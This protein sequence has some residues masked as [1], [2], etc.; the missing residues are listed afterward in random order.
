MPH[1]EPRE[2]TDQVIVVLVA[3]IEISDRGVYS[4]TRSTTSTTAASSTCSPAAVA[5]RLIRNHTCPVDAVV[6]PWVG[7]D[8]HEARFNHDLLGRAIDLDEQPA[9]AVDVTAGLAVED[10]VRALIDLR[11]FLALQLRREQRGGFCRTRIAELVAVALGRLG[12]AL[13]G[14]S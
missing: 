9:D 6:L 8:F 12:G 1:G 11:R 7:S 14:G 13:G 2:V 10:G 5:E 3:E 4:A